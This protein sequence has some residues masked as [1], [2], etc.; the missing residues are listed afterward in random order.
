MLVF[1][2][3]VM[4]QNKP[5]QSPIA[6][7]RSAFDP[8]FVL[9]RNKE[10]WNITSR[11]V[12][13]ISREGLEASGYQPPAA[14]RKHRNR[15]WFQCLPEKEP[16]KMRDDKYVLPI[17]SNDILWVW[18]LVRQRKDE[19]GLEWELSWNIFRINRCKLKKKQL[20]LAV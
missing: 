1:G 16:Q 14:G 8:L 7:S 15:P 10:Q 13:H 6:A 9:E 18:G 20:H 12:T 2:N 11:Y 4:Q 19:A 5:D 17:N 3:T